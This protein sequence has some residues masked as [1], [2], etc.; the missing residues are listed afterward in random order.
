MSRHKKEKNK[1][2]VPL[3]EIKEVSLL[4][5]SQIVLNK[6]NLRIESGNLYF[7]T[8]TNGSGKSS[9]IK[10]ILGLLQPSSGNILFEGDSWSS[11]YVSKNIAYLPQYADLDRTFPINVAELI[12]LSC[13]HSGEKHDLNSH[14]NL[15]T[16]GEILDKRVG[17]LSGGQLQQVM[18]CRALINHSKILIFDEP[19][20][21]LDKKSIEIFYRLIK[22]L[23][24]EGV[25]I[26]I[27]T[28]D[29]DLKD[30]FSN[31][32]EIQ[33]INQTAEVLT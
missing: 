6:V 16:V 30:Q 21:N 24:G 2:T 13:I 11:D 31:A 14:L 29:H 26:I 9:L 18:I 1:K 8:G 28:H 4:Y 22:T 7:F 23:S 3:V 27:V 32:K 10:M 5:N 15:F 12:E 33:F 20:N 19:T 25:T 17:E